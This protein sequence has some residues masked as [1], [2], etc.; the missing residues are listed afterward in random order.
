V[1]AACAAPGTSVAVATTSKI[2]RGIVCPDRKS[3]SLS[4]QWRMPTTA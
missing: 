2:A 4:N 1:L 3:T